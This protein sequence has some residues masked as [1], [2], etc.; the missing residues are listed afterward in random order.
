MK[1]RDV[2]RRLFRIVRPERPRVPKP[3]PSRRPALELLETLV[4]PSTLSDAAYPLLDARPTENQGSFYVYRDGDSG[5]NHGFPSGAYGATA[6][7]HVNAA[8]LDDPTSPSGTTTDP[9]RSDPVHGTVLSVQFDALSGSAVAGLNIQ[10]PENFGLSQPGGGYDLRGATRVLF[11]IRTPT[12]DGVNLQF[13]VA[14]ALTNTVH[15]DRNGSYT[16]WSIPLNLLTPAPNFAAAHVLFT[17]QATA[18]GMPGG[19][20]VLLDN[21]RFDPPPAAHASALSLPTSTQTFGVAPLAAP[22]GGA[23]P[24]PPDQALRNVASTEGSALTLLALLQRG[25]PDDLVAAKSIAD[26][27]AYAAGHDSRANP[28]P[29]APDG[30]S[31]GL[32]NG[33]S[34]GDLALAGDEAAPKPGKQGDAR[35]AGFTLGSAVSPVLDGASAGGNAYALLGLV[36]AFR[37]FNDTH[38]L[39]AAHGIGNWV[40]GNL[41]D[42]APGYG[43]YFAGYADGA[44]PRTLS[45][46][47]ST[48]DNALLFRAFTSLSFA[49]RDAGNVAIGTFWDMAAGR[50]GSFAIQMFDAT[51]G[52]FH[53]GTVPAGTAAG[54][55]VDPSGPRLGNDVV[56]VFDTVDAN[57]IPTLTMTPS[58]L[59]RNQIDWRRPM[60][61]VLDHFGK[62]IQIGDFFYLGFNRT[63]QPAAGPDG[64]AWAY[65]AQGVVALRAVDRLYGEQRFEPAAR[66]YFDSIVKAQQSAPFGDAKGLVAATVAGGDALPPGQQALSTPLGLLPERV[67]LGVTAWAVA[68]DQNIDLV[69]PPGHIHLSSATYS[70]NANVGS[71]TITVVRTEGS[72]GAATVHYATSD[73]TAHAGVN[74]GGTTGTLSFLDGQGVAAFTVPIVNDGAPRGQLYFYVTLSGATGSPLTTPASG[75]VTI[76]DSTSNTTANQ[77]Y[78]ARLYQDLLGR[79]VDGGGLSYWAGLLDRGSARALVAQALLNS[80]EFLERTVRG[81]FKHFLGRDADPN[82]LAS[83]SG[84]LR[85]GGTIEQVTAILVGSAE[86]YGKHGNSVAGF[87]DGLYTDL[88]H[89]PADAGGRAWLT[90]LLNGGAGRDK[91]ALVLMGSTEYLTHLLDFPGEP[92]DPERQDG[93]IHGYYQYFLRRNADGNGLQVFLGLLRRGA[94]DQQV[95]LALVA[96]GEYYNLP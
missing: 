69:A 32:R 6:A 39:D 78:V 91:A 62:T 2:L 90:A 79:Q 8:A 23:V 68:A 92:F 30:V 63:A 19:G 71:A 60:Q 41:F 29:K 17:V 20:V 31:V 84:V 65:S 27:L 40:V 43:G 9:S 95:M 35:L 46:S 67:D 10:D 28:I 48:A 58:P 52:R 77:R 94:T 85:R 45:R 66:K 89:R 15:L 21:I 72:A 44:A 96:S 50:A 56:N 47:K 12:Q 42:S 33:Y 87:I 26:A 51:A 61:Y 49:D 76:S 53:A 80:Q 24:I 16:T 22:G 1:S 74:Y 86:Y 14:G 13:G 82:S 54:P 75:V 81:L 83:F 37:K 59:F 4:L 88:L 36:E 55:G 3:L 34:N 5:F 7:V 93:V 64:I 73:G 11:D 38:Y 70:V 18:A 25:T 57:T